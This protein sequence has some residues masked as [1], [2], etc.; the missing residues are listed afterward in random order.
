MIQW[1]LRDYS[2]LTVA[3]YVCLQQAYR[4]RTNGP[5]RTYR[6]CPSRIM[7]IFIPWRATFLPPMDWSL[8][9]SLQFYFV[10]GGEKHFQ[11]K[12]SLS[13]QVLPGWILHQVIEQILACSI[14]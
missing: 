13:F 8:H 10:Y 12:N 14:V 3:C 9:D 11:G 2:P 1:Y 5:Y 7:G 4:E 6:N